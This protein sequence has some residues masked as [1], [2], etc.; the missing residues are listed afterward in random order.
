LFA[1]QPAQEAWVTSGREPRTAQHRA[2]Q[3]QQSA[4]GPHFDPRTGSGDVPRVAGRI[5]AP[6]CWGLSIGVAGMLSQMQG[7]AAAAG[8]H[9]EPR[10]TR[11]NKP[12]RWLPLSW[13]PRSFSVVRDG[14]KLNVD[15]P[16]RLVIACGRHSV[17][18]AICFKQEYGHQL[19]TVFIQDPCVSPANFDLVVAPEHDEVEGANVIETL[20]A[21][22]PINSDVLTAARESELARSFLARPDRLVT[23]LL[24]GP[25]RCY[26]FGHADV[27]RLIDKLHSIVDRDEVRLI[28]VS[29]RRTPA[30]VCARFREE[31]GARHDVWTGGESN[32]YLAALSIADWIV[33]TGDSVS[34]ASE[35]AA[36]GTPIYVEMLSERLPGRRF[37]RFH[38]G[39]RR[40]GI[41]RPFEGRLDHWTYVPPDDAGRAAEAVRRRM[42]AMGILPLEQHSN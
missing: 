32:P 1:P 3:A 29:S 18:P 25:N 33:V 22:H 11:L 15:D 2:R 20:G 21:L 38:D 35:A 27:S 13:I 8:F 39:F 12:W 7:L 42:A 10:R 14:N 17:I 40:S 30:A 26:G 23:V 9:M 16:P 28:V 31:F 34:M 41:T 24:G 5:G 19:C 4:A 36:T 6:N 37:R